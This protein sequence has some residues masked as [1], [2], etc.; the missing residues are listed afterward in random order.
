MAG[1]KDGKPYLALIAERKVQPVQPGDYTLVVDV[2]SWRHGIAWTLVRDGK[3]ASLGREELSLD[4][5]YHELLILERE[6]GKLKRLGLHETPEGKKL[7]REIK[8][9]RRKLH[10]TIRNM[11]QWLTAKLARKALKYRARVVIDSVLEESRRELIEERLP[12]GLA[13]VY[14]SGIKR[15]VR[16]LVNQLRWYGIP[17]EFRRLYSTICPKC[18]TKMKESHDRIM[19]CESCGFSTHR[20]LVP[21][22]WHL[23]IGKP[24]MGAPPRTDN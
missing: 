24:Q 21:V 1:L 22:V 9:K 2:N 8:R 23:S 18:G 3:I 6:Y 10:A 4:N 12:N 20:D 15:F 19:K 5:L 11:A 17:Y 16:L 7:W 13:K 14:L